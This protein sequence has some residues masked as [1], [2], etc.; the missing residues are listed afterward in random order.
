MAGLATMLSMGVLEKVGRRALWLAGLA[1]MFVPIVCIGILSLIPTQTAGV[2][3]PQ[4]VFVLVRFFAYGISCGPIPFV[5]CGEIGSVRLRQ[6]VG[7]FSG[8]SR[9]A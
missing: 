6:R 7:L 9:S 2:V 5:F 4:G 8:S 1:G 3:W